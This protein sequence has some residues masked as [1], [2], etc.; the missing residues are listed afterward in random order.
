MVDYNG[1]MYAL[2]Y[3]SACKLHRPLRSS[4]CRVCD[5]CVEELGT[6]PSIICHNLIMSLFRSSLPVDS[7]LYRKKEQ[8]LVSLAACG[9]LDFVC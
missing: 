1:K 6:V 7:Q 4:H 5:V 8:R 9:E 2:K 3:C